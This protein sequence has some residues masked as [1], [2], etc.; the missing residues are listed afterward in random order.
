M[1]LLLA[2][3]D[4]AGARNF[5]HGRFLRT[6]KNADV[7]LTIFSGVPTKALRETAGKQLEGT[8]ICELP[9]YR[10]TQASHLWRK[11]LE[12][13]HM[14][15]FGTLPMR[16]NLANGKAHGISKGAMGNRAAYFLAGMCSRPGAIRRLSVLH[17]R[18]VLAHP[19]TASY[20]TL[21]RD[22]SPDLLFTTHQRP[23]QVSPL[24]V[25]ANSLVIP[26]ATFIFSWDKLNPKGRIPVPYH[27]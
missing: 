20:R 27:H 13:A 18:S 2:I 5:V 9:I 3:T 10:E 26:T 24:V 25:A 23:P 12:V 1:K 19:L 11:T 6:L 21:L 17:E 15:R 16:L 14:K 7:S 4:G 8:E 22:L